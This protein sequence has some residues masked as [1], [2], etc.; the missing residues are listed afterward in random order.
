MPTSIP[1]VAVTATHQR[2]P[3]NQPGFFGSV[4]QR[5]VPPLI[6]PKNARLANASTTPK[7]AEYPISRQN[8]GDRVTRRP[9]RGRRTER[10]SA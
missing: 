8:P 6:N 7:N 5:L 10:G 9:S 1:A 2:L 3:S 4:N